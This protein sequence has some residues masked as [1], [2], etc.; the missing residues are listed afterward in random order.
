MTPLHAPNTVR[1]TLQQCA[2]VGIQGDSPPTVLQFKIPPKWRDENIA[3]C[4]TAVSKN[5]SHR[6]DA[7]PEPEI[8]AKGSALE[9]CQFIVR[10]VLLVV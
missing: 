6:M 2:S 5:T 8:L 1:H 4:S 9:G 3:V 10:G 7:T